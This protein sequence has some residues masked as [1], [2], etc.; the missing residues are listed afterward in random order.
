MSLVACL[1]AAL[2]APAGAALTS[3]Q[4]AVVRARYKEGTVHVREGRYDDGVA[5][6]KQILRAHGAE[7]AHPARVQLFYAV[8]LCYL[9][10]GRPRRA[11]PVVK[12][13]LGMAPES[14]K[15]Q[16]LW[17]E[18][19]RALGPGPDP[20]DSGPRPSPSP[21][22]A[23]S[24]IP[25]PAP[26]ST[27]AAPPPPSLAEAKKA[28]REGEAL[29][30]QTLALIDTAQEFAQPLEEALARL[31]T[32][33]R[34]TYRLARTLFLMGTLRLR[35]ADDQRGDPAAAVALLEESQNAEP[36]ANTLLEL[37]TAYGMLPDVEREIAAYDKALQIDP[38]LAE[39][40]FRAALA[41]DKSKRPDAARLTFEHARAAIRAKPDKY[42][43]RFQS[44]LKNSEVAA[45]IAQLVKQLIGESEIDELTEQKIADYARQ[46]EEMLGPG[47]TGARAEELRKLLARPD[48]QSALAKL[49][50]DE[51]LRII[52]SKDPAAIL[53][54][55]WKLGVSP[56]RK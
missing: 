11:A 53:R 36:A 25:S 1:A 45:R 46:F 18:V 55:L 4:L 13:C 29:H 24:P 5:L 20:I 38:D 21:S 40:H 48:V 44:M 54:V 56:P 39:A 49:P 23:P 19:R 51:R 33:R 50:P 30:A 26:A 9:R 52:R 28:Y 35:R 34:A 14:K 32:A 37:G 12:R 43:L 16:A 2:V 47:A 7:L 22:L 6:F 27:P 3:E 41:Y 10:S 17:A 31:Q 42:K 15:V 8:G